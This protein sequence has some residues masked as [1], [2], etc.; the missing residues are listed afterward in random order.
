MRDIK[1]QPIAQPLLAR[2]IHCGPFN[3]IHLGEIRHH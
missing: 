1:S 2:F 3:T